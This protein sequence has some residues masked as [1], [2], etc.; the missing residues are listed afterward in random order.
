[1]EV[2]PHMWFFWVAFVFIGT[3]SL[4]ALVPA[5]FVELNLRD[6]E[7]VKKSQVVKEWNERVE[8]QRHA[9]ELIFRTADEDNS[10]SVSRGEMD[11]F[12]SGKDVLKSLG[13][14]EAEQVDDDDEDAPA[15]KLDVKQLRMEFALVYD[16]LEAE[17]RTELSCEEFIEAFKQLRAKPV[18][19]DVLVL[20]QEIFKLRSLLLSEIRQLSLH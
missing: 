14:D 5:I 8:K 1:M 2:N 4:M 20:Q 13:L 10:N 7:N 11:K 19:P 3:I 9:L 15:E 17:G 16:A 6:A 12:L 18:S